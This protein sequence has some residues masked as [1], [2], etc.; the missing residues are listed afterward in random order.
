[1]A[2]AETII[3]EIDTVNFV[4]PNASASHSGGF[5]IRHDIAKVTQQN[6]C[7]G[8][9]TPFGQSPNGKKR[10]YFETKRKFRKVNFVQDVALGT[11]TK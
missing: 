10:S 11:D 8:A 5:A 7:P 1:M 9:R 6:G 2:H 3:G 4:H